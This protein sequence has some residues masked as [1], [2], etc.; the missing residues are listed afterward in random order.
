M[1]SVDLRTVGLGVG[2]LLL[3]GHGLA[4]WRFSDCGKWLR[5]FPRSRTA[6][7]ILVALAGVWSF[8]LV[9]TMDL[10]EFA[11]LR[12]IM[13]LAIAAGSFLAWRYVEEFLAVRALGMLALLAAEPVLEAAFLRP[14]A[15][16]LL[17]VVLAYVWIVLGLFWVGMP[18]V[19]RDQISWLTAKRG[20]LLA[21]IW[22]G[23]AYGA[24]IRGCA[25]FFWSAPQ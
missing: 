7:T 22:G 24:A 23:I 4:L 5:G 3:V 20:R 16:R 1:Y 17:V 15:T 18:W 13:L 19:M 8:S 12:K 10:G 6:G 11:S 9:W 14:E 21:V 25:A 2:L